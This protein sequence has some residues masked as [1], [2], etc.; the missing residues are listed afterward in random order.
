VTAPALVSIAVA[1]ASPSISKG[2]TQQFTATGTYTDN[3]TQNLSSQVTWA[4]A[5][6][7]TAT[8]STGGL[9]TGAGA[10]TSSISATLSGVSG[11]TILTVTAATLQSIAVMPASPSI[12]K[13]LTQQFTATGT[14]TDNSTQ[15]L[16][17]QVTWASATTATATIST[18]GLAT[19]AGAG[20]SSI[21]ATLSGVSGST[22]LTVTAATLQ[23]ILVTP[24]NPSIVVGTAEQFQATGTY[25]DGSIQD[26]TGQVTWASTTT[27]VAT[28]TGAGKAAGVKV[29]ASAISAML[30]SVSGSTTL[31][32]M[33]SGPCDVTQQG[34]YT[35]SDAQAMIN[36]ALGVAPPINDSNGDGVVNVVDIQIVIN[37]VL[38]LGCT[39]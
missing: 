19:G 36:E 31:T 15:N 38:N 21:S 16:S 18:G 24:A 20:T 4:S 1:P 6:T 32:V 35:V 3:S 30:G 33:P 2:L 10:G 14:Y 37:A 11:S 39:V 28:I 5:T 22:I 27:A 7:A 17:S 12:S 13:G 8:I 26:L 29:G 25:T 34:L 23:S 9:A